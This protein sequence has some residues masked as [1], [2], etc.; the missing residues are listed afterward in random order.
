MYVEHYTD[1]WRG[2]GEPERFTE[3]M[4]RVLA[5]RHIGKEQER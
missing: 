2:W 5:G 1:P 3:A 4:I